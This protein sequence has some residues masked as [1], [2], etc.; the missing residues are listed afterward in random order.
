[1][2]NGWFTSPAATCLK[3]ARRSLFILCGWSNWAK[4]FFRLKW[5]GFFFFFLNQRYELRPHLAVSSASG[6]PLALLPMGCS[7][8]LNDGGLPATVHKSRDWGVTWVFSPRGPWLWT[9][10]WERPTPRAQSQRGGSIHFLSP[11]SNDLW[12][13]EQM[14]GKISFPCIKGN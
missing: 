7:L 8:R 10:G 5:V 11:L 9:P 3:Q 13:K 14:S 1:M 12:R 6:A 4:V 2:C